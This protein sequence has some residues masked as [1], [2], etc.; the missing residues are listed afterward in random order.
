[1]LTLIGIRT[2]EEIDHCMKIEKKKALL[3]LKHL[4]LFIAIIVIFSLPAFVETAIIKNKKMK[5]PPRNPNTFDVLLIFKAKR[6]YKEIS[7]VVNFRA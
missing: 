3:A 4:Y 1:M 7:P 2:L 5:A 6:A